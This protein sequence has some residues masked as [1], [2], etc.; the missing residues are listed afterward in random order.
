MLQ[1]KLETSCQVL[2]QLLAPDPARLH[3]LQQRLTTIVEATAQL[4]SNSINICISM[5]ASRQGTLTSPEALT[6]LVPVIQHLNF[7]PTRPADVIFHHAVSVSHISALLPSKNCI[8]SLSL[9]ML[10]PGFPLALIANLCDLQRLELHLDDADGLRYLSALKRLEE[11]HVKFPDQGPDG[12]AIG[13]VLN[14]NLDSLLHVALTAKSW[15]DETYMALSCMYKLR[16]CTLHVVHLQQGIGEVLAR[17]RAVQSLSVTITR[18]DMCLSSD[19][20]DMTSCNAYITDL[21][22]HG[23]PAMAVSS[24]GSLQHLSSLTLCGV[25]LIGSHFQPQPRIEKLTIHDGRMG[26]AE[27]EDIVQSYPCLKHLELSCCMHITPDT[28]CIISCLRHLAT[29]CLSHLVG[30]CDASLRLMEAFLR[31]Q[32]A[33]GMAQPNIHFSCKWGNQ[34]RESCIDYMR[35]PVLGGAD[36]DEQRPPLTE[37]CWVEVVSPRTSFLVETALLVLQNSPFVSQALGT[38]LINKWG[39]RCRQIWLSTVP[40]LREVSKS[41]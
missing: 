19:L 40:R 15:D 18:V 12:I 10:L 31:A 26:N 9:S 30:L 27:L 16:T 24:L 6:K 29:L 33:L 5:D 37:R 4:A 13:G 36:F 35:Y 1:G 14:S 23:G 25:D 8:R 39:H 2:I 38:W 28:V 22:L 41:I 21:T 32:Q 20:W 34:V 17:V 7:M 11:L 3:T